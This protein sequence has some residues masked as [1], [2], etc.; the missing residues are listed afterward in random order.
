MAS[1]GAESREQA[2]KGRQYVTFTINGEEFAV[3]AVEVQE[4]IVLTNVTKVPHLPDYLKGVI[5]LRGTVIPV[6]DLKT[7][8]GMEREGSAEHTCVIVTEFSG[9]IMGLIVDS[10]SDVLHMPE[11][12]IASPPHFGSRLN[13]DF[14]RGIGRVDDRL[15]LVLDIDRVLTG[16]EA[17]AVRGAA[18][19]AHALLERE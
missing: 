19:A 16:G 12:S 5:S 10:V 18:E 17:S 15:V 8:F 1:L 14:I 6:V 13:T 9:G 2:T 11:E 3:D 7:K 4:I